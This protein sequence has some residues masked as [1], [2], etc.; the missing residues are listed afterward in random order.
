MGDDDSSRRSA[1]A[2]A[3]EELERRSIRELQVPAEIKRSYYTRLLELVGQGQGEQA[4]LDLI[5]SETNPEQR[6]LLE[7]AFRSS[8]GSTPHESQ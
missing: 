1:G 6:L 7:E 4:A 2:L 3:R 5:R 8:R